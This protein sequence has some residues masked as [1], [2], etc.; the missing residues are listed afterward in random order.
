[1]SKSLGHFG[2]VAAELIVLTQ[3]EL[4]AF[5]EGVIA[6]ARTRA[7]PRSATASWLA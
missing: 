3:A 2:A 1:M 5:A 6:K 7:I 4:E